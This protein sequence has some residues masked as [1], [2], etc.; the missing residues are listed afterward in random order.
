MLT[1]YKQQWERIQDEYIGRRHRDWPNLPVY[2]WYFNERERI[3]MSREEDLE[4][5]PWTDDPIMGNFRFTNVLRDDDRVSRDLYYS[6]DHAAPNGTLLFNAFTFRTFNKME[7]WVASGG[8]RYGGPD[9][10]M[11]RNLDDYVAAGGS[12]FGSAYL[13]TNSLMEGMPKHHFYYN[14]F[15]KVWDAR[16]GF[17][18]HMQEKP[19]LEATTEMFTT[20]PGYARFLG[21]ELALDMQ[22]IGLLEPT[23]AYTWANPGP[24]AR[25][26]LNYLRGR[27][28]N[29]NFKRNRNDPKD[30]GKAESFLSEMRWLFDESVYFLEPHVPGIDMRCIENGLCETSKYASVLLTGKAKRRYKA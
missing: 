10:H 7:S 22:M 5:P 18:V 16:V 2:A 17:V 25:R 8:F 9:V 23:D 15:Y 28:R 12:V 4:P 21:Y 24:G 13:M 1:Q 30:A 6:M 20:I 27:D 26:G 3:R 14:M 29:Y 19:T 11:L